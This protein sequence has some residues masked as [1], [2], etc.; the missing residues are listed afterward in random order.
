[1]TCRQVWGAQPVFLS[2][3]SFTNPSIATELHMNLQTSTVTAVVEQIQY[4]L[5]HITGVV[6]FREEKI[7]DLSSGSICSTEGSKT[8]Q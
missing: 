2:A 6:R 8:S 7:K 3:V 1:M 4:S 5:L